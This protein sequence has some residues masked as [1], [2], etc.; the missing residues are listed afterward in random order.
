[1][2]VIKQRALARHT[3][4]IYQ[5]WEQEARAVVFRRAAGHF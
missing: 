1:M 2:L 4:T 5:E 3:N